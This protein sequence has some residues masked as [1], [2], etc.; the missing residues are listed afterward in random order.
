MP[1]R[2]KTAQEKLIDK[3]RCVAGICDHKGANPDCL[4]FRIVDDKDP[5]VR[6]FKEIIKLMNEAVKLDKED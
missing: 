6:Q 4:W 1:R 2:S 5:G 3:A